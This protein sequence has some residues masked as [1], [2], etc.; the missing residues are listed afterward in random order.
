MTDR[1][2]VDIMA[3]W[4]TFDETTLARPW[5]WRGVT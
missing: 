3:Q 1:P 2:Y 5:S 4:A